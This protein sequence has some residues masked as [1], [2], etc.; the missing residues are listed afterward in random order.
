[1]SDPRV[2]KLA[3]V[4]VNYSLALQPG[5]LFYLRAAP[6]AQ[7]LSLAVYKEAVLAGA[8]V[9]YGSSLPGS[10]EIFYRHASDDQLDHVDNGLNDENSTLI[11]GA[12]QAGSVEFIDFSSVIN[13][14]DADGDSAPTLPDESFVISV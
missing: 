8:H 13:A 10:Q 4:L 3:Q 7:E 2:T 5:D 1:M 9:L 6:L 11:E 12:G 14:I